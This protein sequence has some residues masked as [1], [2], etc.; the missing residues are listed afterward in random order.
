MRR[1]FIPLLGLL[2]LAGVSF[3]SCDMGT[4]PKDT[5]NN[6]G[7]TTFSEGVQP[8]FNNNCAFSGCHGNSGPQGGLVL[9]EGKAYN[10]IVSVPSSEVSGYN[11]IEPGKPDSSF[12][13]LKIKSNPPSGARM[14]YGGPYL[15]DSQI[16]T[17]ETW[18]S[19]GAKDN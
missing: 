7:S 13:Y 17:I 3:M 8:I 19:D 15:S 11:R 9:A 1:T 10:N 5:G 14:P 18:I 4:Q 6:S 16:S 2:A 12:L